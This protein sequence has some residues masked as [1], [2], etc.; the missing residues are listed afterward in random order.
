MKRFLEASLVACVAA[1]PLLAGC[2]SVTFIP[3]SEGETYPATPADFEVRILEPQEA[4]GEYRVIG[5]VSCRDS[6]ASSIWNGWTDERAL[7]LELQEGNRERLLKKI[8]KVGGEAL[9]GL[10]HDVVYGGSSGGVGVGVGGGSGGVGVGVGTTILSGSPKV[11]VV[12][13]GDV[14]VREE[15][16]PIVEPE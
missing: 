14:G 1:W 4:V 15:T 12:S 5:S 8:R 10:K 16:E 13:Y 11:V 9:I 6:A 3:S 2:R 7:I